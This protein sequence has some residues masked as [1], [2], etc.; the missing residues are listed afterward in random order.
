MKIGLAGSMSVGKT[1]L[2]K[3][4]AELPEFKGYKIFTERS[5]ELRDKGIPLNN[6]STFKGQLIFLAERASELLN[7]NMITDRTVIDVAAFTNLANS[8]EGGAKSD[9]ENVAGALADDYDF[10]FY[11]PAEGIEIENNGIRE[12]NPEYRQKIDDEIFA[13]LEIWFPWYH[14]ISGSTEERIDQIKR[15]IK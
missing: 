1:T 10:I 5:K 15:I 9:F 7:E 13:L 2:A 12:T 6:D 14:K 4:L 11:I 8:I 3:T